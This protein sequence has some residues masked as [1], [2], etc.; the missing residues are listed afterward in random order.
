MSKTREQIGIIL[1]QLADEL[2]PDIQAGYLSESIN[3]IEVILNEKVKAA[4]VEVLEEVRRLVDKWV[5]RGWSTSKIRQ[6]LFDTIDKQI[7]AEK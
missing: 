6:Y 7:K 4:R 3:K 5:E 2:A 1:Q